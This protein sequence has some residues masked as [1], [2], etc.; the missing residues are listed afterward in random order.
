MKK[1]A[2]LLI[3]LALVLSGCAEKPEEAETAARAEATGRTGCE[4]QTLPVCLP[5]HADPKITLTLGGMVTAPPNA[6]I[7]PNT[8]TPIEFTIAPDPG[9]INTV[10]IWPKDEEDTWLAGWNSGPSNK[11]VIVVP[12]SPLGTKYDYGWTNHKTGRCVDPRISVGDDEPVETQ[13][14][15]QAGPDIDETL[16]ENSDKVVMPD[17]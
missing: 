12:A 4:E 9:E 8:E 2:L 16:D 13:S 1:N 10:E 3:P 15:G 17:E 11:I 5:I 14:P 6:C 7:K